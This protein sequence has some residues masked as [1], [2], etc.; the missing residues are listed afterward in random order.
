MKSRK[1]R[2]IENWY[3]AFN[4]LKKYYKLLKIKTAAFIGNIDDKERHKRFLN[5]LKTTIRT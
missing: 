2:G 1:I 5:T 4:E 3:L